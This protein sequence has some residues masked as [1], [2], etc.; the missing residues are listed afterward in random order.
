M[1]TDRSK[2]YLSIGGKPILRH[3]IEA[4]QRLSVKPSIA[5]VIHPE[6]EAEYWGA[7]AGLKDLERP[8]H[9]GNRRQDSVR[10][11]LE[12]L[13]PL[14]PDFV[15]IHDAAR[16]FSS[17]EMITRI[18]DALQISQAV[19]PALPV[20]DSLKRGKE[21]RI[22]GH[23]DREN[24]FRAQTPQGFHFQS[25]LNAHR[26]WAT[27]P[28]MTDDAAIAQ[29]DGIE[30]TLVEGSEENFKVTTRED[31]QRAA[32]QFAWEYRTGNGFDVHKLVPGEHVWLCGVKIPHERTLEGHSDAD[33]ALHA[34][35]DALLGSIGAGD[36]GTHFP[37]SEEEWKGA[38]SWRFLDHAA[39][40]IISKGGKITHVDVTL[41][42]EKPKIGPHRRAMIERLSSILAIA[43]DRISIKAT[44]TEKLGFTGRGE[45]IAAQATATIAL[46][47]HD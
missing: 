6:A 10:L 2:Q 15:L 3:T 31:L 14:R 18:L 44:T 9:G 30:V 29:A 47:Y 21:K 28:E 24:L 11:G 46:P 36:I 12:H 1:G 37:P 32:K 4:F 5:V 33:V 45:G 23:V 22:L 38:A 16:P 17:T 39:K 20:T 27:G 13:V 43:Q 42:C 40:L 7:V 35:T 34:L 25:I 41:I 19:I 26:N 8:V